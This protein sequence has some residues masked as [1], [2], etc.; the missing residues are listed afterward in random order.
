L[1]E[2]A[3]ERGVSTERVRQ[4]RREAE[5]LLHRAELQHRNLTDEQ[6]D[7]QWMRNYKR[8]LRRRD[9]IASSMLANRRGW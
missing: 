3:Q 8:E 9:F 5:R 6:I 7:T 4:L 2:I 1:R